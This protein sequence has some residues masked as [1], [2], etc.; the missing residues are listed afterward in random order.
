MRGTKTVVQLAVERWA[1]IL[2]LEGPMTTAAG[3]GWLIQRVRG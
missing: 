3:F 1:D 2:V